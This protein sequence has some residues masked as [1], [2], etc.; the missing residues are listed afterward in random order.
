MKYLLILLTF[1]LSTKTNMMEIYTFTTQTKVNEWR[2]VNDG[3]MGGI[4]KSSLVLTD[5][6]HGQFSGHVS[7]ENNGGFA[8]IQLNST[9]KLAKEKK[10]IVLRVKGDG[11]A[12][13]FRLKGEISQSESYVHQFTTKGEWENI[14]LP[15]SEFYPQFRGRKLN[16]P[17]FNFK[18]IEQVSFLIANKQDEDFKLLIDWIGLE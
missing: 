7:L 3:V 10:F 11:K 13:E 16:I 18:S 2:I 6:G 14:K 9:I 5:A 12:Y 17:N 1:S 8:S 4:S 15:I